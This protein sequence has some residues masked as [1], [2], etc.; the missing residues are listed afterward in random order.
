MVIDGQWQ[1]RWRP[2]DDDDAGGRFVRKETHYRGAPEP[3]APGRYHLY[4]AWTCPWAHRVLLVRALKGLT[5]AIPVHIVQ[6]ALSD[7]G[8]TFGDAGDP[9][10]GGRHLWEV[11][12]AADPDFTGRATVPF[13][14]D[15]HTGKPV[16]NE[17]S[18]LIRLLDALPSDRP[19]LSPP[20]LL[21]EL[22]ALA[23]QL[24][25]RFN[26]GVYRAGFATTQAA[27]E[28]AVNDV[29]TVLDEM[30]ERLSDGRPWLL[31]DRLTEA[32]L[33]LF[34]T[35][36][37]FEAAYHGLFRCNLSHLGAYPK[38]S[39]HGRRLLALPG[40]ADT[41]DLEATKRGYYSIERLNPT[42]LVPVGPLEAFPGGPGEKGF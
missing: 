4:V 14:V 28:E 13:L 21:P 19:R 22:D 6:P 17:S 15:D 39:A 37:R 25:H 8:W 40:V 9:R 10:T 35:T 32:D 5:D 26:N 1:G 31:G 34:V 36:V 38:V 11:Y 33:R 18:E 42:G 3:W 20:E 23:D 24:Y 16:H 7:Q 30:E 12:V 2:S 27:Y 41:L 29:F